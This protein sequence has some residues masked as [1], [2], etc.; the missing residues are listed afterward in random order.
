MLKI[1]FIIILTLCFFQLR[2]QS[3]WESIVRESDEFK[4]LLPK[5]E[6]KEDWTALNFNDQ[7]WETGN[8]GFGFGDNDDKTIVAAT[9]SMFQIGRA[10]CRESV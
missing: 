2:S 8:G 9:K 5:E 4:Y 7:N 1:Q 10:S 6:P 3:H